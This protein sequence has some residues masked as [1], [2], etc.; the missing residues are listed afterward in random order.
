MCK[1]QME[2]SKYTK[3]YACLLLVISAYYFLSFI[4]KYDSVY[5]TWESWAYPDYSL[6]A[7]AFLFLTYIMNIG[8]PI[9]MLLVG[10]LLIKGIKVNWFIIFLFV[11]FLV[12][13][14]LLGKL[15]LLL[16]CVLLGFSKYYTKTHNKAV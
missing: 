15:A 4:L 14:P 1:R 12:L 10:Y 6:N 5:E 7:Y 16:G 9:I 11:F 3:Y 2:I 13:A 8:A